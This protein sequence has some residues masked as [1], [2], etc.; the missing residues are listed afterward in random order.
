MYCFLIDIA[1]LLGQYQTDLHKK[2]I[3][4][5]IGSAQTKHL[6]YAFS[7]TKFQID[8]DQ[9]F[10]TAA[11]VIFSLMSPYVER[12]YL[13]FFSPRPRVDYFTNVWTAVDVS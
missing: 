1:S 8:W 5:K 11:A 13:F 12:V 4:N 3:H 2:P 10:S 6:F 9:R 7:H